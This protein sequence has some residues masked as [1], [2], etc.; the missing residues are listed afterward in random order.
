MPHFIVHTFLPPGYQREIKGEKP[1]MKILG[2]PALAGDLA[3]EELPPAIF[4][5][6]STTYITFS[7]Y[8][9]SLD[10]AKTGYSNKSIQNARVYA[11]SAYLQS[12]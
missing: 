3:G 11:V 7:L 4:D 6:H 10:S 2:K 8:T 12:R 9:I 1:E 5:H